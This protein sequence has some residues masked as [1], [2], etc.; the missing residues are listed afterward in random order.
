MLKV[1]LGLAHLYS[2]LLHSVLLYYYY[3]LFVYICVCSNFLLY[4]TC[5]V[6]LC[7]FLDFMFKIVLL[8]FVPTNQPN[9][10]R[11]YTQK[12]TLLYAATFKFNIEKLSALRQKYGYFIDIIIITIALLLMKLHRVLVRV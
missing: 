10:Y 12:Q 3:F 1:W 11:Y 4:Y 8:S 5:S 9:I 7:S 6:F 2:F